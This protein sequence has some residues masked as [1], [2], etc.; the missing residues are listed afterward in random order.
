M[1]IELK[2]PNVGS[3][4]VHKTR[5]AHETDEDYRYNLLMNKSCTSLE[6]GFENVTQ[7]LK[8]KS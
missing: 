3:Y 7:C 6:K 5:Q 4:E 1:M 8:P 2:S